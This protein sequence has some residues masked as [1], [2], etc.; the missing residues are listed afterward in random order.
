M[1]FEAGATVPELPPLGGGVLVECAIEWHQRSVDL[2]HTRPH[3]TL[4]IRLEGLL[5]LKLPRGTAQ[6][7][8]VEHVYGPTSS[9]AGCWRLVLEF[10]G[11]GSLEAEFQSL[12]VHRGFVGQ[13]RIHETDLY[14]RIREIM[15]SFMEALVNDEWEKI[16]RLVRSYVVPDEAHPYPSAVAH[17]PPE[18]YQRI[19]VDTIGDQ[20]GR[21]RATMP[22]WFRYGRSDRYT[23][24][25]EVRRVGDDLVGFLEAICAR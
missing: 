8:Q 17:P 3:Q 1:S 7:A 2:L 19:D 16:P 9:G 5:R 20:R 12:Q 10:A 24:E 6:G 11:G 14:S 23:M 13:R 21:W 4:L 22:L 18:A 15:R 25:V